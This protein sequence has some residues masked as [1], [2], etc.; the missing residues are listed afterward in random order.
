MNRLTTDEFIEK[1]CKVHNNMYD[2]SEV[3]YINNKSKVNI[4]C[5]E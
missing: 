1:S 3:T 5:K 2:Y 4:I